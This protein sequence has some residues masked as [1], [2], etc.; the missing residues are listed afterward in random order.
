MMRRSANIA[1][2]LLRIAYLVDQYQVPCSMV[3]S[4]D[5]SANHIFPRRGV[6]RAPKGATA[7]PGH[8]SDD[9]RVVTMDYAISAAG[10]VLAP[11]IIFEGLTARAVPATSPR[12]RSTCSSAIAIFVYRAC[13]T[14][15]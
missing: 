5:Q 6:C 14:A 10:D 9:K 2:F 4:R 8:G 3:V 13:R 11:Q 12:A 1:W 15:L 7:V